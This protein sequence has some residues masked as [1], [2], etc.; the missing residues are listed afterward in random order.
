M[1]KN[2]QTRLHNPPESVGNCFPAVVS[3]FLDLNSAEDAMQT[4]E[5]C[6]KYP[7]KWA[8]HYANYLS[9]LGW[10]WSNLDEPLHDDSYYIA[11]GTTLRS[12]I[13]RHVCIYKNG[14][15]WHDPHPDG[16]GL[17]NIDHYE[18]LE[19]VGILKKAFVFKLSEYGSVTVC[20]QV[21]EDIFEVKIETGFENNFIKTGI[22][23]RMIVDEVPSE[24]CM[25]DYMLVDEG[26]FHLKLKK[27]DE[28]T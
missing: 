2:I 11:R 13:V 27:K 21:S 15:L 28:E 17:K 23:T 4:E 6:K 22:L 5:L 12:D 9:Q 26:I 14:E 20:K 3:C 25:I 24:F 7:D 8:I 18:S 1:K 19:Y 10:V 16:T